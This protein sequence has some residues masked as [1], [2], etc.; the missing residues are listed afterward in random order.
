MDTKDHY[1]NDNN[2]NDLHTF[3]YDYVYNPETFLQGRV[4]WGF[5][6]G[7]GRFCGSVS[8]QL[9]ENQHLVIIW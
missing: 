7:R 4:N 1:N 5:Y 9:L 3:L 8:Q 2:N 6:K